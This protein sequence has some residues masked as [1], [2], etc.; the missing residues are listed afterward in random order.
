MTSRRLNSG[1]R[2]TLLRHNEE[3]VPKIQ[4]EIPVEQTS[5]SELSVQIMPVR[6][7]AENDISHRIDAPIHTLGTHR[8]NLEPAAGQQRG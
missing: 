5:L 6:F 4:V 8:N 1:S 7:Q 2:T 3:D